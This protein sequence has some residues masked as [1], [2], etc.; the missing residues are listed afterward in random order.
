MG[1][2]LFHSKFNKQEYDKELNVVIE[3]NVRNL[4]DY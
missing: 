4:T 1:D 3:E 2:M